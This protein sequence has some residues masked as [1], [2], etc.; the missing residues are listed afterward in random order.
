[1]FRVSRYLDVFGQRGEH[2]WCH[3]LGAGEPHHGE[4]A[5]PGMFPCPC[6]SK[7][8]AQWRPKPFQPFPGFRIVSK[9]LGPRA[10]SSSIV[11]KTH[12]RCVAGQ[13]QS[14][15]AEFLEPFQSLQKTFL[16]NQNGDLDVDKWQF[17]LSDR[18]IQHTLWGFHRCFFGPL[19]GA[20]WNGQRDEGR[21]GSHGVSVSRRIALLGR[22]WE[23]SYRVTLYI[24][25]YCASLHVSTVQSC[26]FSCLFA[27][28]FAAVCTCS[29]TYTFGC[30]D[31]NFTNPHFF[32][33]KHARNGVSTDRRLCDA[34]TGRW[35]NMRKQG[36]CRLD[37]R[38]TRLKKITC[39]EFEKKIWILH[40]C[41]LRNIKPW[42]HHQ[43]N[44]Q[45]NH[46]TPI[47]RTCLWHLVDVSWGI[48][49]SLRVLTS[50]CSFRPQNQRTLHLHST[51]YLAEFNI[52][53]QPWLAEYGWQNLFNVWF[54]FRP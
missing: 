19:G 15:E 21:H 7:V 28:P 27:E 48:Q 45:W 6:R 9:R 33:E 42:K 38:T 20:E 44:Y 39:P 52:Q 49:R 40:V 31:T 13:G 35:A 54:F 1:M 46:Q 22:H 43:W 4:A 36:D 26:L 24:I 12:D 50:S 17:P 37:H 5:I 10:V 18:Y 16:L 32:V 14:E 47:F 2:V 25:L 23:F 53:H 51:N 11:W 41:Y 8:K 30:W 34:R 29:K 3:V